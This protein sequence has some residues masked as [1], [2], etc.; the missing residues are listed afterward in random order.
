MSALPPKAEMV[1]LDRDV[2]FVPCADNT[3]NHQNLKAGTSLIGPDSRIFKLR[4]NRRRE[5]TRPRR[6]KRGILIAAKRLA[7]EF[8]EVIGHKTHA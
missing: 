7:R 4:T 2:R 3:G 8:N 5:C 1:E 6:I